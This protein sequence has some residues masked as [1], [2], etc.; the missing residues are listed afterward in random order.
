MSK[1]QRTSGIVE[2]VTDGQSDLLVIATKNYPG[3][4]NGLELAK[5]HPDFKQ[6]VWGMLDRLAADQALR[7]PLMQRPA[8][9]TVQLGLHQTVDAYRSALKQNGFEIGDWANDIM[10]KPAFTVATEPTTVELV[11][12]TVAELGFKNGAKR[13]D[14][15]QRVLE[16]G[17]ELCPAEVGPAL[18][19]AYPDQPKNKWIWIGMEPIAVSVG[20]SGVFG[21]LHDG[22]ERWLRTHWDDPGRHWLGFNRW[23]FRRK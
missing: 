6:E 2:P 19:L 18:G 9:K 4:K 1:D 14:I 15:Y 11:L 5:G 22:N 7:L 13:S 3:G 21:V 23:V 8:W 17:F 10:G 20:N 12:M 16:L